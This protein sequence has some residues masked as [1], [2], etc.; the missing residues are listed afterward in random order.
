MGSPIVT[1]TIRTPLLAGES[2]GAGRSPVRTPAPTTKDWWLYWD[3]LTRGINQAAAD[4]ADLEARLDATAGLIVFANATASLTLTTTFQTIV[5]TS[6][7]LPRAGKYLIQATFDLIGIG[8]GDTGAN[9]AG[10]L[11][12]N[13]VAQPAQG[14]FRAEF[15][16]A[17][18]ATVAQ[19]WVYQ[20]V[21]AGQ[22]ALLQAA[23]SSG[24]GTS[25]AGNPH[26]S[27]SAL[28]VSP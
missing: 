4:I 11:L 21:T 24:T 14:I 23:K 16:A 5:G 17:A 18:R 9:L 19:Q 28:W 2:G 12:V 26:T 8:A 3:T 22:T 27:I 10:Q 15:T 7:T 25:I 1:P 13:G 6:I 20:A